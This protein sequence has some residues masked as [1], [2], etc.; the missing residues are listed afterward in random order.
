MKLAELDLQPAVIARLGMKRAAQTQ[1]P[2]VMQTPDRLA[3]YSEATLRQLEHNKRYLRE[4]YGATRITAEK[5]IHAAPRLD[6]LSINLQNTNDE[7]FIDSPVARVP[8]HPGLHAE[9]A[10]RIEPPDGWGFA[11]GPLHFHRVSGPP[12]GGAMPADLRGYQDRAIGDL[13]HGSCAAGV[14]I[15]VR[16]SLFARRVAAAFNPARR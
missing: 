4:Q 7:D 14:A 12:E 5:T 1:A 10:H 11:T 8:I 6:E 15:S 2:T 16:R 3:G 9:S 13:R